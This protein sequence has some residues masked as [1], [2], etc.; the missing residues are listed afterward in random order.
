MLNAAGSGQSAAAKQANQAS[1]SSARMSGKLHHRGTAATLKANSANLQLHCSLLY[2]ASEGENSDCESSPHALQPV[3][4]KESMPKPELQQQPKLTK[5]PLPKIRQKPGQAKL[6]GDAEPASG[7][8][9]QAAA[10]S[11]T[12]GAAGK[13]VSKSTD[14][15]DGAVDGFDLMSEEDRLQP[16]P[17]RAKQVLD[18]SN[19][20]RSH[21]KSP[22]EQTSK[23]DGTNP[24]ATHTQQ[25][26]P[27][28]RG[29]QHSKRAV[30]HDIN[31][32][33]KDLL[34]QDEK[35]QQAP[36]VANA[37]QRIEAAQPI[38]RVQPQV[39]AAQEMEAAHGSAQD[40]DWLAIAEKVLD[41]ENV[42]Q[43]TF[44]TALASPAAHSPAPMHTFQ[45]RQKHNGKVCTVIPRNILMMLLIHFFRD[46]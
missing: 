19:L 3:Q 38:Q 16:E 23:A 1:N 32:T 6:Q 17:S 27:L 10:A 34:E 4:G 44:D 36:A 35:Q 2:A 7:R 21:L 12:K 31:T 41:A 14:Q 26:L 40:P 39:A 18:A 29:R 8:A 5:P 24:T 30:T 13:P 25:K 22:A 33:D 9:R 28:S 45:P 15:R 42:P 37:D 43:D 46:M 11:R 20:A